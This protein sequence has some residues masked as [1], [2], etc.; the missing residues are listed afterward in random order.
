MKRSSAG[1]F[2]RTH[3]LLLRLHPRAFREEFGCSLEET[4]RQRARDVEDGGVAARLRH[5]AQE[6][7]GLLTSL[8]RERLAQV[9]LRGD[10][11]VGSLPRGSGIS[12][13]EKLLR[14]I[15]HALRRL[16]KAP[17]F[18]AS[19][20]LTLGLAIGANV[21][22]F[23]LVR[24]V[25][26]AP[27]PYA[28]SDRLVLLSHGAQLE[29]FSSAGISTGLYAH[30]LERSH[31]FEGMALYFMGET[32][33]SGDGDPERIRMG[34][35]MPSLLR[36]LGTSPQLGRWFSEA[37]GAPGASL[38][39][40][41]THAFWV[42]RYGGD[43]AV[44]GRRI[45]LGGQEAEIIGVMPE[46]FAFPDRTAEAWTPFLYDPGAVRAGGF[47]IL[48]VARLRSG[49]SAETA[50]VEL[51]QL[52]ARLPERFP[53]DP[54]ARALVD[55]ARLY[56]NLT[57]LKT[58][59]IGPIEQTLWIL[60]G[61]VV[62]VL[63]VACAN[64]AN[65]FLVRADIRQR[66]VALRRALGASRNSVAGFFLSESGMLALL[67]GVLGVGLAAASVRL[68][69]TL[70][71]QDLPR[72]NEV[73]I[74]GAVLGFAAAL[75]ALSA[76]AFGSIPM[77]RGGALAPL[78]QETGRGNTTS[79]PRMRARHMLMGGQVALALILLVAS[80][81][82]GRSFQRMLH[83]DPGFQADNALMFRAGLSPLDHPTSTE[84]AMFHNELI[85][86]VS[87]LPGVTGVAMTT[88]PPL[89]GI[90]TWD[91]LT[92]LDRPA[93]PGEI[94][95][96]TSYRWVSPGYFETLGIR[97]MAGRYFEAGDFENAKNAIIDERLAQKYFPGEDPLGRRVERVMEDDPYVIVGV[98]QHVAVNSLTDA[99]P[100]PELYMPYPAEP[101]ADGIADRNAAYIVRA[102]VP[103]LDLVPQIRRIIGEMS[104]ATAMSRV[105]TLEDTL[106]QA[107]APMAFT[108]M[109]LAIAAGVALLLGVIGI[110]G[111]IT[112]AVSQRTGEIGVRLALGAR[113]RDVA[114]M[115]VRQG[116]VVTVA[117]ILLGVAGALTTTRLMSA[118]LF[119]VSPSD[120]LT[121]GSVAAFLAA[122]ALLACWIPARR[123]ARLNPLV[124]LRT[125]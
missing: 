79:S 125:E 83:V 71:P 72:L 92:V 48:G 69:V 8:L 112:Y 49:V 109:L 85:E 39:V 121:Y 17:V 36:V 30:Y 78:L 22:I 100:P 75:S 40:V 67:G 91:P 89:G 63:L 47:E 18:T 104:P 103:P 97:L 31:S 101:P 16:V 98:V 74:D 68:L 111:V 9:V 6:T 113:P 123:A 7:W 84:V 27:L 19:A 108:M 70:G 51:N 41:L 62:V 76:L 61:A 10:R 64:V 56:S 52:I 99:D 37:E 86:R 59:I 5:W 12:A 117:G 55:D 119:G 25:V 33:L 118:L 73:R 44:L 35:G 24:R 94:G 1:A 2:S 20:V 4:L 82:M 46:D 15:R 38:A 102:R 110:Y 65:L 54:I 14:E 77:L 114:A 87:A 120:P 11:I 21:A 107:R 124:A 58:A 96:I 57:T 95:A 32:T 45:E 53:G 60:M 81:L 122:T 105:S 50:R 43:A 115:V 26:L 23:T 90:C 106:R 116:G 28:E 93:K 42:R 13:M 88:C 3:R 80:V 29:G 34:L 66:E